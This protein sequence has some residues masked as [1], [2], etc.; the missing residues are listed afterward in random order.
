MYMQDK[1]LKARGV[2]YTVAI[3]VVAMV[4]AWRCFIR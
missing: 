1:Y 4:V 2:I 3:A